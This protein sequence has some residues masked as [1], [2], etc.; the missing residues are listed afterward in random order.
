MKTIDLE[1][2]VAVVTG[3]SRGIG[4]AITE[5]LARAGADV[6]VNYNKSHPADLLESVAAL[7]RRAVAVQADVSKVAD[8]ERLIEEAMK[9]FGRI[10]ILVNNAGI[11]RDTLLMRMDEAAWDDVLDT[12][13]KSVFATCRA[14]VRPM[15]KARTGSII[16]IS[17]I[18]GIMGNAGQTNYAA[19]KAGMIGFSKSLA[20]ETAPRGIRVN[21]VAP[22]FVN[23]DM[24][25]GLDEKIRDA[26][27]NEIPLKRFGEP[28]D[29]ADAVT[30]LASPLARF[31]TGAVLVVDGGMSM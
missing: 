14:A 11:T 7:G 16:N 25:N 4:R 17:S 26:V 29:I 30:Y 28:S 19:S 23:S 10:D 21:V 8:C 6:V 15:M 1:G 22:G 13:L 20:R 9:T 27:L 12:N 2:Q 24:T 18:S 31:V 3:G 5:E